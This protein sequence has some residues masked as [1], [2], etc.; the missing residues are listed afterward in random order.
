MVNYKITGYMNYERE[1][2]RERDT[3]STC[4]CLTVG[5]AEF[6]SRRELRAEAE[7]K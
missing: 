4:V 1:R 3:F 7:A 6:L 5:I 2:E